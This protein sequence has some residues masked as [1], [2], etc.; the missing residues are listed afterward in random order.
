[1]RVASCHPTRRGIFATKVV[2]GD[3]HEK[4]WAGVGRAGLPS[5]FSL[6][7]ELPMTLAERYGAEP[8]ITKLLL[9]HHDGILPVDYGALG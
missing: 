7:N 3:V 9:R 6:S 5:L 8:E 1:M 2:L 4:L